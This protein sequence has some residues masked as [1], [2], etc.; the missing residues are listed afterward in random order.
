MNDKRHGPG[1]LTFADG[2]VEE[3]IFKDNNFM[4]ADPTSS[5]SKV[6]GGAAAMGFGVAAAYPGGKTEED[7]EDDH[8]GLPNNYMMRSRPTTYDNFVDEGNKT[9]FE[10]IP[11][12]KID[13][14]GT[15]NY[16]LINLIPKGVRAPNVKPV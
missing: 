1:K 13:S 5:N 2:H 12:I 10:M 16:L 14:D 15:F 7:D 9:L 8:F 4:G 6:L 11:R 3:G